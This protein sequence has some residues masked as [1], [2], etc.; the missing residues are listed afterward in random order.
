MINRREM[1]QG[2]ATCVGGLLVTSLFPNLAKAADTP[3]IQTAGGPKRVIFFLQNHGFDPLTCIP[4]DLKESCTLSGLTLAEPM[5]ALEPYKN[6][7]HV[8]TGLHGRH[9]NPG[10]SAFFGALGGYRGGNGVP[11]AAATID[12]VL[13]QSLPQTI[14]PP[15]C[16]GMESLHSMRARPTLATLSAAGPNQP[17]AMHCDPVMLYQLLFGSIAEGAIKQHYE[18]RSQVMLEVEH[19][20]RLKAKGLPVSEGERYGR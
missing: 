8:I 12:Y 6:R 20:A 19:V 16:I 17:I 13:S 3:I 7:M 9:T 15:L 5:K 2:M 11:P 1:L 4:N 14:L 10:H 18:A